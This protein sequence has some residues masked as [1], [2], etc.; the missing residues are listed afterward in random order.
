MPDNNCLARS[1]IKQGSQQNLRHFSRYAFNSF[2][3]KRLEKLYSLKTYTM[4]SKTN[5]SSA[6]LYWLCL[7]V[8]MNGKDLYGPAFFSSK[9]LKYM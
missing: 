8:A 4:D 9:I 1:E 3:G 5:I 6:C 2:G 7:G